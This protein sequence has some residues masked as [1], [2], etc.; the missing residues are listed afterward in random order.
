[1][2]KKYEVVPVKFYRVTVN[3]KVIYYAHYIEMGNGYAKV[4]KNG[5]WGILNPYGN[6]LGRIEYSEIFD[7]REDVARVMRDGKY[8]YIDIK[9]NRIICDCIYDKAFDFE[10]GI[11]RVVERGKI[12]RINILGIYVD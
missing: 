7:P 9:K 10:H 12:R 3:G 11:A 4:M 5:K 6:I 2:E 8:G 1:M